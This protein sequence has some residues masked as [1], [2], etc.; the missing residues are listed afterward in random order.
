MSI[1][2]ESTKILD[3]DITTAVSETPGNIHDCPQWVKGLVVEGQ[4]V[5]GSGG[6]TSKVYIQTTF[7]GI[8]WIDIACLAFTTTSGKRIFSLNKLEPVT[9]IHT[10]TDGAM[11]DN[12][13][14]D[15]ILGKKIR[16]KYVTTGT[17]AGDTNLSVYVFFK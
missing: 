15:G 14:K 2:N 3:L 17:Y 5:Y 11:T 12:T 1:P 4:F 13:S 8:N 7:D 6:T 9:T 16:T 10:P